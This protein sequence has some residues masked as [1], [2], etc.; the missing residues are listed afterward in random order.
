MASA[1]APKVPVYS[2]NDLKNTTD[3][4]FTPYLCTLPAPYAFKRNNIKSN[5]RLVVGYIA[6]AIAGVTFYLDR[7]LGWEAVEA[8]WVKAAVVAYFILNSIL[9][10]WIW[11]V[12]AGEVFKGSRKSG[13][14]ITIQ[15]FTKKHSPLYKLKI[16]YTAPTGKVLQEKEIEAPFTAWFSGDGIFHPEPFRNWLSGEIDVLAAAAKETSKKTGN[17]S[18]HVGIDES[19]GGKGKKK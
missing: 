2:L 15:S 8:W 11:A 14:T 9:T 6:V 4:A 7:Q 16:T 18:S 17:V 19:K 1:A 3:D 13:E 5:V 10:Y 12:E